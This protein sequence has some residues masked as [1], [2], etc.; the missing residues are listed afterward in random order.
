MMASQATSAGDDGSYQQAVFYVYGYV[1]E[2]LNQID[3]SLRS[4]DSLVNYL[5]G[6]K[7]RKLLIYASDGLPL[8][9][10]EEVFSFISRLFPS[11]SAET[12]SLRYDV[13]RRSCQDL[14]AISLP[15]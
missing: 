6:I 9:P 4:L 14:F 15:S 2:E 11:M 8:N 3:L 10:A 13:T 1:E 7:G 12:E 5:G